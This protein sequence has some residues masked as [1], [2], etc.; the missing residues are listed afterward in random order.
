MGRHLGMAARRELVLAIGQGY[1]TTS[2]TKKRRTLNEFTAVTG[3][4]RK[5]AIR[6]RRKSAAGVLSASRS[7]AR[8]YD[9]AVGLPG[10]LNGRQL[11]DEARR[12]RPDLLVLF[13]TGYTR[14]AIIHQGRLD[15]GAE[16]IGKPFTYATL[17]ANIQRY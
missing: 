13:T 4:H 10:G 7:R 6:V 14:N 8:L 12:R 3:Y 15:P 2:V 1:K 11:A 9:E 16:L 17:V 5:H